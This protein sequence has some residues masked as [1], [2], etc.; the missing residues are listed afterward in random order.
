[1]THAGARILSSKQPTVYIKPFCDPTIGNNWLVSLSVPHF[2]SSVCLAFMCTTSVMNWGAVIQ[3]NLLCFTNSVVMNYTRRSVAVDHSLPLFSDPAPEIC[4][5][6][7]TSA[8]TAPLQEVVQAAELY[9][10]S[11]AARSLLDSCGEL[12]SKSHQR[13]YPPSKKRR[14]CAI[15]KYIMHN[16]VLIMY[17]L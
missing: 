16:L 7:S 10:D 11:T 9:G 15:C 14:R 8:I 4:T 12:I 6:R 3:E 17:H 2:P 5:R 13:F 1:M